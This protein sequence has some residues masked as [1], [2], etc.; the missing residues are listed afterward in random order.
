MSDFLKLKN[1]ADRNG[2]IN[3]YNLSTNLKSA[4]TGKDGWGEVSIA[5]DN[6]RIMDIATTNKY[7]G[8]LYLISKEEWEKETNVNE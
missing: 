1:I 8:V 2:D 6:Y 5:V 3:S 7:I 4:K